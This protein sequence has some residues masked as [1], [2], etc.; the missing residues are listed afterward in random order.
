MRLIMRE[1]VVLLG[2][3]NKSFDKIKKKRKIE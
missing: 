2:V 1:C 3:I